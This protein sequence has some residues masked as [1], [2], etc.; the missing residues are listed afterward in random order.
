[1]PRTLALSIIGLSL[2]AAT[3]PQH[4]VVRGRIV[5]NPSKYPVP[6][7]VVRVPAFGI[8]IRTDTLGTFSLLID[9]APGCYLFVFQGLGYGATA[10][11][12]PLDSTTTVEL[13]DIPLNAAPA[14]EYKTLFL[15][16]CQLPDSMGVRNSMW[17][18]DTVPFPPREP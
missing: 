15:Q 8:D 3:A 5:D 6:S 2:G 4:Y 13:G 16:Q 1:M 17:G 7:G 11:S 9:A 18:V 14:L 10:R 12:V